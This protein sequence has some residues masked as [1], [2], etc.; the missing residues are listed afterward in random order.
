MKNIILIMSLLF[1]ITS[2]ARQG[3]DVS[4]GGGISESNILY[5]FTN[6]TS[7]LNDIQNLGNSSLSL[8]EK[9]YISKLFKASNN[10][11]ETKLIFNT[12]KEFD[13]KGEQFSRGIVPKSDIYINLDRIFKMENGSKRP[14][15]L[16]E[17]VVF[18]I[19]LA[20]RNLKTELSTQQ[21]SELYNKII[22]ILNYE[23]TQ[24]SQDVLRP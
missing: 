11:K 22:S 16:L 8:N 23:V 21:K 15:T 24:Q 1:S 13:F 9:E 17:S 12:E 10:E 7:Y 14:F 4:G 6:L 20:D 3:G 2:F 19:Q 5:S 18:S